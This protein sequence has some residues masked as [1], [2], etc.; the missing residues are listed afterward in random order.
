MFDTS[1]YI[2]DT[3]YKHIPCILL[4]KNAFTWNQCVF[5]V[6]DWSWIQHWQSNL[7][8]F[9]AVQMFCYFI[10]YENKTY[11]LKVHG[12]LL[13][14]TTTFLAKANLLILKRTNRAGK[15]SMQICHQSPSGRKIILY[16]TKLKENGKVIYRLCFHS[17]SC[18]LR[19]VDEQYLDKSFFIKTILYLYK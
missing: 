16:S 12:Q 4:G 5:D 3:N 2:A 8:L 7:T 13:E 9:H 19:K 17:Q 14:N 10:N 1:F 18:I 11:F 15:D 6:P